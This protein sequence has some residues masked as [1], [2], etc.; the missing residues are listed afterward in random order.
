MTILRVLFIGISL[1]AIA[2][3]ARL[4]FYGSGSESTDLD[5]SVRAGSAGRVL[6][7]GGR[8]K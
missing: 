8:I 7:S 3:A 1:A 2:G 4:D 5:T 6:G